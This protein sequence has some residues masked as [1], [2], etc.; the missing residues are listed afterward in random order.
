MRTGNPLDGTQKLQANE[1][2]YLER[3]RRDVTPQLW[4]NYLNENSTGNTGYP[5]DKIAN[6]EP[7]M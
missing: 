5:A 6:A 3:R 2:S 4:K 1:S 7:K